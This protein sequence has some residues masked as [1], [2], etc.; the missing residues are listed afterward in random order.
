MPSLHAPLRPQLLLSQAESVGWSVWRPL[1]WLL[2]RLG[3]AESTAERHMHAQWPRHLHLDP[4][5]AS[6]AALP[7]HK[8]VALALSDGGNTSTYRAPG[9]PSDAS[10]LTIA[11]PTGHLLYVQ[12]P[13]RYV[14][15]CAHSDGEAKVPTEPHST[16]STVEAGGEYRGHSDKVGH[17]TDRVHADDTTQQTGRSGLDLR[18][19]SSS[20]SEGEDH[21]D[22]NEHFVPVGST[23]SSACPR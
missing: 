2:C 22:H 16:T 9:P 15:A 7:R 6:T 21:E 12:A 17:N 11:N 1:E 5:A 3:D 20:R 14:Y 8:G 13:Q 23:K 18:V 19:G 4:A 10:T